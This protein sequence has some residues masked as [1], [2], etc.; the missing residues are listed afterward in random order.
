MTS[1]DGTFRRPRA[2]PPGGRTIVRLRG[3]LNIDAAPAL[4]ERLTDALHRGT[5]LLVLDLSHVLSCDASL[6]AVLI[7]TQRRAR[8]L[9]TMVRLAAPSSPVTQFM[10]STG[11]DRSFTIYPDLGSALAA[12]PAGK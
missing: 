3:A 7:G 4:R 2:A 12:E 6:L 9:G 10:R 5:G 8:L 1:A 11:L